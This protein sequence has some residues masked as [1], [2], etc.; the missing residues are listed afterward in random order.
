MRL[1][2]RRLA[3]TTLSAFLLLG[4]TGPV[5][6]AAG[7]DTH[8]EQ[9]AAVA[10][11]PVA[12]A[13]VL[14][15]Q[16]R[17]L[18]DLSGV[19][20]PTTELLN[21]VLRADGGRLTPRESAR[22]ARAVRGAIAR[23]GAATMPAPASAASAT[24][25]P[26]PVSAQAATGSDTASDAL[27][28]LQKSV[29]ILLEASTAGDAAEVRPAAGNVVAD[30][31]NVVAVTLAKGGMPSPDLAAPPAS[32]QQPTSRQP[33]S[34]QSAAQ[35]STVQESTVQQ[36]ASQQAASEASASEQQAARQPAA[37]TP[38]Q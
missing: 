33:T 9:A 4:V 29:D 28:A 14:L 2:V 19:L 27:A 1:P 37:E 31:V 12:D 10:Q 18:G 15:A 16:S 13:E 17:S 21:A 11:E 32:Q 20:K 3:S 34:Q 22:H 38:A 35:E 5:A 6:L 8:G 26:A 7:S 30:L 25:L 23:I 36:P 24:T